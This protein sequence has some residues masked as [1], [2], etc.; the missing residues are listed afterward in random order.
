V[1]A[2]FWRTGLYLLPMPVLAL[3]VAV[4]LLAAGLRRRRLARRPEVRR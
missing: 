2:A 3:I 4:W 1:L